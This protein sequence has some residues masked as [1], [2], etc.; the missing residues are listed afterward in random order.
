MHPLIE[1]HRAQIKQLA[2]NRG[3]VADC[4][5]AAALA[6]ARQVHGSDVVVVDG[7]PAASP[8]AEPS[9]IL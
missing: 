1:Q 8:P 3:L 5:G 9:I 4:L 2:R 6:S 7:R